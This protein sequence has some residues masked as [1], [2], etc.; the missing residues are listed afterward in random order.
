MKKEMILDS[1]TTIALILNVILINRAY[2]RID[3]LE[4]WVKFLIRTIGHKSNEQERL[5]VDGCDRR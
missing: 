3:N 4:E 2:R 5:Y 1:L